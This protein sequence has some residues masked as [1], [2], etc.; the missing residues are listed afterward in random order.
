MARLSSSLGR[1]FVTAGLVAVAFFL[2]H[3]G[4][5]L[6]DGLIADHPQWTAHVERFGGWALGMII[7]LCVVIPLYRL[8]GV[9]PEKR[10]HRDSVK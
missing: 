7:G 3:L 2:A 9:F 8:Y 10:R 5:W 1:L 4:R 6:L